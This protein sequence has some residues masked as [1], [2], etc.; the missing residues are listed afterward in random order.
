MPALVRPITH[1]TL[2]ALLLSFPPPTQSTPTPAFQDPTHPRS[3]LHFIP[4]TPP[5]GSKVSVAYSPLETLAADTALILRGHFRTPHDT[6]GN[7]RLHN[8][9]ITTL[10]PGT[11]GTFTGS[12]T[13]PGS[14]V[15]AAL[16]VEDTSGN[17]LDANGERQFELLTHADDGRP[18]YNALIQRSY[19]FA[20]RNSTVALESM[21]RA[22]ELYPDSLP[23]WWLLRLQEDLVPGL[24]G[25][26]SLRAWHTENFARIHARHASRDSLPAEDIV[27]I[28]ARDLGA[29]DR[30]AERVQADGRDDAWSDKL[31]VAGSMAT[32]PARRERGLRLAREALAE[33]DVEDLAG[34]PGRPLGRT[35][36]EYA[37]LL[38]RSR[39]EALTN[40]GELLADAGLLD[41]VIDAL[42][43]AAAESGVS[44]LFRRL[45]ELR[46]TRGDS[47]DAARAFAVVASDPGT[48]DA[49][50]NALARRVGYSPNSPAWRQLRDSAYASVLLPRVLADTVRWTPPPVHVSD[51]EGNRLSLAKMV[52]GKPAVLVFWA[53]YCS[54]CV[55]EIPE[56]ARLADALEARGVRVLS[57]STDDRPGPE[58]DDWLKN[59]GVTYPVYYDLDREA[60]EAFGVSAISASFVLDPE[61]RVRFAH[62]HTA[63]IRR[64]LEALGLLGEVVPSPPTTGEPEPSRL[65]VRR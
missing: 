58:M 18:L 11:N 35:V 56:L 21:R 44:E 63:E 53:R 41:E 52:E 16:V 29:A 43:D 30:W 15:C 3:T 42:E 50:A 7:H 39:A 57:V 34:H 27:A 54:P 2:A 51:A 49:Q 40:Y 64:Q 47:A 55:G 25:S 13:L 5:P 33:L 38:A 65:P 45:G 48:S 28:D 14:A 59:R 60:R 6:A 61:G 62:S 32:L 10:R 37:G 12:F 24:S 17:R 31:F 22:M 23:G 26:D 36:N 20:D 46:L 4:E 1:L 9:R 19:D 8:E